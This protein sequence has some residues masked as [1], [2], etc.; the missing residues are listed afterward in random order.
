MNCASHITPT[1][2]GVCRMRPWPA[3]CAAPESKNINAGNAGA[4]NIRAIKAGYP[5]GFGTAERRSTKLQLWSW[6]F[7]QLLTHFSYIHRTKIQTAFALSSVWLSPTVHPTFNPS[8]VINCDL[9]L[10][11]YDIG[12][13]NICPW[14][15]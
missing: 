14:K 11:R 12:E 3:F 9:S 2:P 5:G 13:F 1:R 10:N 4:P 6:T 8:A 7:Y 15:I